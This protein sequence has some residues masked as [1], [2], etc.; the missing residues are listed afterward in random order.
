MGASKWNQGSTG[1]G[2]I[3]QYF[4]SIPLGILVGYC[5]AMT[6]NVA[7][8]TVLKKGLLIAKRLQCSKIQIS[9]DSLII[10]HMAHKFVD[11]SPPSKTIW[12]WI[13]KTQE[14]LIKV[15]VDS[16]PYVIIAHTLRAR[17]N[18]VDWLANWGTT[19]GHQD[20][21]I[22]SHLVLGSS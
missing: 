1:F 6:N 13:L 7:K 5:G 3:L 18:V 22:N 10:I 2:G 20:L 9:G 15:L 12:K 19:E 21:T 8:L 11:R 16:F 14:E 4:G 17:N